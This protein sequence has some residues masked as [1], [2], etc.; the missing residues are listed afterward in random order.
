[1]KANKKI[2]NKIS[3]ILFKHKWI[4]KLAKTLKNIKNHKVIHWILILIKFINLNIFHFNS[5]ISIKTF[6]Y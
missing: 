3:I 5:T 6:F 1:M 4:K 2:H